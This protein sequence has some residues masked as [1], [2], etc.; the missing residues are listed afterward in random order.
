MV[1]LSGTGWLKL[2]GKFFIFMTRQPGAYTLTVR[3]HFEKLCL[4]GA[5]APTI[6]SSA[7]DPWFDWLT[8]R[9]LVFL[10]PM[11]YCK[12]SQLCVGGCEVKDCWSSV[13][14]HSLVVVSSF[15]QDWCLSSKV[16]SP[17]GCGGLSV[18]LLCSYRVLSPWCQFTSGCSRASDCW[19][20]RANDA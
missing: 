3:R 16:N 7:A 6:W 2:A 15:C 10:V 17:G 5:G 1:R 11:Q 4:I 14:P 9:T 13:I 20:A 8:L 19:R 12:H 18:L